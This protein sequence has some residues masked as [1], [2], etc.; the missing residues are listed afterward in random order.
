VR[1]APRPGAVDWIASARRLGLPLAVASSSPHSW[2]DGHLTRLG[3][4]GLFDA[5]ICSDDV[6]PGRTKPNPDLFLRAAEILN[7]QPGECLVLE[8]SPNGVRA[9][10]AAGCFVIAVPNPMTALLPFDGQDLR[11]ESLAELSLDVLLA[12]S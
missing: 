11:L 8:D 6:P 4:F 2:V 1:S 10:R 7:V 3:L 5:V 12:R 9:G